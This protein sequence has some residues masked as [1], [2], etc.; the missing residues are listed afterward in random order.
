MREENHSLQQ[1]ASQMAELAA[2]NQ[3][4]S[5]LLARAGSA[6]TPKSEQL[7][8]L[9]RLRGEASPNQNKRHLSVTGTRSHSVLK[10]G[11]VSG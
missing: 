3:R 1:L 10:L 8:E 7:G 4:L 9:L 5:N 6:Q 2:E 11:R